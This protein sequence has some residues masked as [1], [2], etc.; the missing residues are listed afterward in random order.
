MR[1]MGD[2]SSARV[3]AVQHRSSIASPA[4]AALRDSLVVSW[5]GAHAP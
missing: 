1:F 2:E 4:Q 5:F 3:V